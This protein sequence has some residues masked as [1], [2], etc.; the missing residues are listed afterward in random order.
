[1]DR[2]NLASE[3]DIIVLSPHLDDAVLSCGGA[4]ARWTRAGRRVLVVTPM[5]G[6]APTSASDYAQSLRTRWELA[7]DAEAARRAEDLAACALLSAA[8]LHGPFPDCIYRGNR[9]GVMFYNSDDEIFGPVHPEDQ[10]LVEAVTQFL[11]GLPTGGRILAPLTVGNHVDHVIV[12][13]AAE[14]LW[15]EA[16]LYYEDFPYAQEPGA[17]EAVLARGGSW[18]SHVEPVDEPALRAKIDAIRAYRSQLSTFWTDE[19]DLEVQVRNFLTR[20]G[21]E[22]FWRRAGHAA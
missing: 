16:L 20:V 18:V 10:E 6:D 12:R 11:A 21:G 17:V 5:A 19:T 15:G 9:Q 13:Q 22:R 8:A 3:Y 1:M 14:R 4:I 2:E 7:Q